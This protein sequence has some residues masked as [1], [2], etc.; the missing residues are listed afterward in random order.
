MKADSRD[1]EHPTCRRGRVSRAVSPKEMH[2][3]LQAG[4]ERRDSGSAGP[5]LCARGQRNAVELREMA[6]DGS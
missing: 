6:L 4:V 2:R 3:R 5:W 1:I